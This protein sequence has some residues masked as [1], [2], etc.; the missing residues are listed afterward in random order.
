MLYQNRINS[1][2]Y[3]TSKSGFSLLEIVIAIA[4]LVLISGV[5]ITNLDSVFG[6]GQEN[7]ARLFVKETIRTPLT[8]YRSDTG[9]FP[10]TEQGLEALVKA[11]EGVS[12]WKGPYLRDS[13]VPKDPWGRPY[14]YRYP[15]EKN[16][17][18]YDVWSLGPDGQDNET[19]IGNW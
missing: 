1:R 19:N 18:S 9:S 16:P 5:V 17:L 11:P 14:Q 8:T 15:G 3:L 13:S 4:L 7:T 2:S 6:A 10:T 12:N